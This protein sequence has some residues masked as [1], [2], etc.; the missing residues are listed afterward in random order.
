[1]INKSLLV[2]Y[3]KIWPVLFSPDVI[4]TWVKCEDTFFVVEMYQYTYAAIKEMRVF[5][6]FL[7]RPIQM[8]SSQ[9][10]NGKLDLCVLNF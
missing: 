9:N 1:M 3:L 7:F 6:L 5:F 4:F 2:F 10:T 8:N